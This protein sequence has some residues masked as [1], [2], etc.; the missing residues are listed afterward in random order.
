MHTPKNLV[1]V[2][3]STLRRTGDDVVGWWLFFFFLF[4]SLFLFFQAAASETVDAKSMALEAVRGP[5]GM[6]VEIVQSYKN[7]HVVSDVFYSA[8]FRRRHA[9]A[10]NALLLA[11]RHVSRG[12]VARQAPPLYLCVCARVSLVCMRGFCFCAGGMCVG[13]LFRACVCLLSLASRTRLTSKGTLVSRTTMAS[14]GR[15]SATTWKSWQQ[16]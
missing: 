14:I 15:I 9:Q 8:L 12:G 2:L 6:M 4:F 7:K 3:L 1:S 13:V 11:E 16:R 5:V 10:D